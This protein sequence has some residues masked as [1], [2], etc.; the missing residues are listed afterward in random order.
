MPSRFAALEQKVSA[1]VDGMYGEITRIHYRVRGDHF[2]SA[3]APA[4]VP[5]EVV[6]IF[7]L[8]PV[9]VRMQDKS[10]YDGFQPD[11]VG[12]KVH[13]SYSESSFV[14]PEKW[15]KDGDF[16]ELVERPEFGQLRI[17][18][19]DPDGIGRFICVCQ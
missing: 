12:D 4:T 10:Q 11:L 5:T 17:I 9:V 14:G 13:V 16:I 15:P 19:V 1:A 2:G 6:G 3:P 18:R 7:D 8:K